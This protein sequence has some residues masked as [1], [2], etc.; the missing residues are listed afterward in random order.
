MSFPT[1]SRKVYFINLINFPE[2]VESDLVAYLDY[3]S[4][5]QIIDSRLNRRDK[6]PSSQPN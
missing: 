6:T 4:T 5:F 2:N 1:F 3:M